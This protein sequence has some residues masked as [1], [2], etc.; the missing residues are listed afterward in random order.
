MM[1]DADLVRELAR[2]IEGTRVEFKGTMIDDA[3]L[4][5]QL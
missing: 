1:V 5:K 4:A 3:K 2:R